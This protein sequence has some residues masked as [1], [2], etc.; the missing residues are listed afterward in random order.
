MTEHMGDDHL[1]LNGAVRL[2]QKTVGRICVD[3]DLINLGK[4]EIIHRLHAV[5]SLAKA[6]VG[7]TAGKGVGAHLI[8]HGCGNDLEASGIRIESE[9]TSN[10]PDLLERFL[11]SLD[12]SVFHTY[13]GVSI[14]CRPKNCFNAGYTSCLSSMRTPTN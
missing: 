6:P 8:H 5:I 12:F 11:K 14:P 7:I 4:A 3:H 2:E 9:L 10:I 1:V 13:A